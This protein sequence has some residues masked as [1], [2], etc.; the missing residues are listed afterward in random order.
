MAAADAPKSAFQPRYIDIGIN[1]ADPI[2][3]GMHHGKRRHPDDLDAVI[4]RAQQV[5][6][7][8]LIVTGSD[9]TSCRDALEIAKQYR[10]SASIVYTTIGIHPCSSA[11]FSTLDE[12]AEGAHSDPDPAQAIPEH[13]QP[14]PAKTEAIVSE[15]RGLINH[16][17]ASNAGLVA[18]GEFG[19][20]YDRLH[21]CSRSI[22][23]HSF[24]AQLD[25]VLE[26]QPQLPLFLHS[27]AAHQDFVSLLKQKFGEKLEKLEKGGVV[28]S[29]T[30]T[31]EEAMELM[32]LGLYIGIN[33]CSFKTEENC[34]V[35]KEIALDKMMLETDGPWCEIRPSHFGY[36]Y[37]IERKPDVNGLTTTAGTDIA[38]QPHTKK[39]NQKKE[40]EVPERFKVVKKEKWEEGAMIKGRNEPCTIERVAKAVAGIKEVDVEQV[41][42]VAWS[43]TVKV[44]GLD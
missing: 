36:K 35:V 8:K 7:S 18:L 11:I 37:L 10:A 33:G 21:Y 44:F 41:C 12:G 28:H 23:L 38:A 32:D 31:I 3:R 27:R 39:K 19:L 15:L 30:G 2:F 5:G 42:E 6:C 9:F 13:H 29:F 40:S 14:D 4:R 22:Q 26:I 17:A 16:A 34:K 25:L 43:N 24:A 20:D 1:L